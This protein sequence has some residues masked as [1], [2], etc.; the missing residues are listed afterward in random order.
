MRAWLRHR[1]GA[2]PRRGRRRSRPARRRTR[3]GRTSRRGARKGTRGVQDTDARWTVK[4]SKGKLEA[5]GTVKRDIAIPRFGYKS[6]LGID[7]RHGFIRRRKVSAAHEGAREGLIDPSNTASSVWAGTAY[8]SKANEDFLASLGKT[9]RIHRK[10][11]SGKPMPERAAKA[12]AAKSRIRARV[13]H[14]FA[15]QKERMNL[16][17]RGIGLKRAEATIIMVNLACNLGR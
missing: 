8:R 3:S 2:P 5:D 1:G 6:H 9:S 11:P 16:M 12:N 15:Q 7:R 4:T 10:K 13:E 17:I 14:V